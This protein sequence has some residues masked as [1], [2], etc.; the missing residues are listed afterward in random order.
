MKRILLNY[1]MIV[2]LITVTWAH[3]DNDLQWLQDYF[4]DDQLQCCGKNDC[5]RVDVQVL[6][7]NGRFWRV[8]INDKVLELQSSAVFPSEDTHAYYCYQFS[9]YRL[10]EDWFLKKSE[11]SPM[12][13][14]HGEIS[15][16]CFR[17][18]FYPVGN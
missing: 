2:L 9:S 11:P 3:D 13:C 7:N 8:R 4:A 17:C 1:L 18:L 5:I 6:E 16:H 14:G 12:L 10:H 15:S